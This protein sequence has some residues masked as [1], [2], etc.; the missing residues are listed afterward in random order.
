M[1]NFSEVPLLFIQ[2]DWFCR[3]WHNKHSLQPIKFSENQILFES[4]MYFEKKTAAEF[5]IATEL[6]TIDDQSITSIEFNTSLLSL[7]ITE[8]KIF[9]DHFVTVKLKYEFFTFTAVSV[10]S[11]FSFCHRWFIAGNA[12]LF[13]NHCRSHKK[14]LVYSLWIESD[15]KALCNETTVILSV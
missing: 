11:A 13:I 15:S 12:L 1:M 3:S 9:C 8:Y 2:Y 14:L 5:T 6:Y 10:Y 7:V 4:I